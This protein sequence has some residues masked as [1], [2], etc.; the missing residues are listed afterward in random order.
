MESTRVLMRSGYKAAG[1]LP[2]LHERGTSIHKMLLMM[3]TV[4]TAVA[5]MMMMVTMMMM[6]ST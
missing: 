2:H 5:M 6:W 3:V 1:R 4:I